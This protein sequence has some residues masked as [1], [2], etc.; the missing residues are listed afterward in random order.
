M[1]NS[2]FLFKANVGITQQSTLLGLLHR[3]TTTLLIGNS[4]FFPSHFLSFDLID[5]LSL[6]IYRRKL[7]KR[8][9]A[10]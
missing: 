6:F 8:A 10:D 4:G 7:R 1:R 5:V 2:G 9:L 3:N